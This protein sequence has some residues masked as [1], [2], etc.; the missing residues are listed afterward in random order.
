M[1]DYF[2]LIFNSLRAGFN[3][4]MSFDALFGLL[5][6]L[7]AL[8]TLNTVYRFLLAP[9][10]SGASSDTVKKIRKGNKGK[11]QSTSSRRRKG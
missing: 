7:I 8:F 6:L 11:K 1:N 9:L 5:A 3:W 4:L 2:A 10:I